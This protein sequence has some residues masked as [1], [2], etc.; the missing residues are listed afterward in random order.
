MRLAVTVSSWNCFNKE[1]IMDDI[2]ILLDHWIIVRSD[3][4]PI[5]NGTPEEFEEALRRVVV[6]N[7][8]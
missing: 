3:G 7:D 6:S 1:L 2:D 5:L 8:E 4:L